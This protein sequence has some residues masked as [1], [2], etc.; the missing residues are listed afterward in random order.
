[1][2]LCLT[3]GILSFM[4]CSE[5][6]LNVSP[7]DQLQTSD[8][9]KTPK[10]AEQ[11][12]YGIYSDLRFISNDEF[13]MLSEVRSDNAWSNPQPDGLREYSEIGTFRAGSEITTF[14]IVW[15]EWYKVILDANTAIEKIPT[16]A[17]T[18]QSTKDQFMGEAYFLRGWAYFELTRL[19]G[20]IPIIDRPMISDEVKTVKQSTAVDVYNNIILPDM[21]KAEALLPLTLT[22]KTAEGASASGLGRADKIATKAMLG[23]IYM[24]MAGFPVNSATA[25][26]SAE[27]KLKAVLDFSVANA[28]KF[29]AT[30][31][32]AWKKQWISENNNLYSIFAI[33]HRSGGTGNA[34]TFNM[35]PALPLSYTSQRIFG[36]QIYVEKSLMY[37]MSKLNAAGKPDSRVYNTTILTGYAAETNYVAYTNL[38]QSLTLTDGTVVANVY[39]NTMFYKYTNSLRKRAA[40]GYTVNI[41]TAMKDYNDWP[42][43]YPVIR[44]EDVQLMYAEVLL[45]KRSD[46]AGALA[47]VN[48]IRTRAGATPV[49][50][51]DVPSVLLAV[52][53]ERRIELCGEGV[54]WFDLVRWN[55]WKK[56]IENKFDRYP[57]TNVDKA[58]IK[59]GRYLCPIPYTQM[60]IEPGLYTQNPDYN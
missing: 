42:V 36:N 15:N 12:L 37:E 35:S 60:I 16:I 3:L 19:F 54:R 53:N 10:Q 20:N 7:N 25:Q 45:N 50:V 32:T 17:F 58:N 21:A 31:S 34:T 2:N 49:T 46:V 9:Y 6:F 1:M 24:T 14:N 59:A 4:S 43:N 57:S 47:I 51:T 29:W 22:L 48:K 56:A 26:D 33:Q 55:E 39:S 13:L 30:D 41:E 23:R 5:D 44:L 38:F 18:T 11:A 52:K 28:N 40:L 27:V 8:S